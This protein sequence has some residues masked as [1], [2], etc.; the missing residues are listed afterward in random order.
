MKAHETN[1]RQ[2]LNTL[3]AGGLAGALLACL[4]PSQAAA[5]VKHPHIRDAIK[6][7]REAKR[8]LKEGDKIF[9]GHRE[10]AL[11]AVDEAIEQLERALA[12]A[13]K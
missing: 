13:E 4:G 5:A 10:K 8:E 2:M 9:G 6:E 3:A 1:R 11:K 7:L 12:F